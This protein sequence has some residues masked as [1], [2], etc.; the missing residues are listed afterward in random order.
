M[1]V[2]GA[3]ILSIMELVCEAGCPAL[4]LGNGECS[5]HPLTR[6]YALGLSRRDGRGMFGLDNGQAS[7]AWCYAD[8]FYKLDRD[9]VYKV[10]LEDEQLVFRSGKQSQFTD[11]RVN[12]LRNER[13]YLVERLQTNAKPTNSFGLNAVALERALKDMAGEGVEWCRLE[14]DEDWTWVLSDA[15]SCEIGSGSAGLVRADYR[16]EYLRPM[17]AATS[18]YVRMAEFSQDGPLILKGTFGDYELFGFITPKDP[19][20][21]PPSGSS[22][23]GKKQQTR[24]NKR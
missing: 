24:R 17:V 16:V 12:V 15:V 2:S 5:T 22:G 4:A 10:S 20:Y 8:A 21:V 6:T 18:P 19:N 14:S 9:E 7:G 13:P 11:L 23:K 1:I 3:E